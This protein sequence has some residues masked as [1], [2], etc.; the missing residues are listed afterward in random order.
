MSQISLLRNQ[1]ANI[2]P[3]P[4]TTSHFAY[5][6]ASNRALQR[7]QAHHSQ[8]RLGIEYCLA[9]GEKLSFHSVKRISCLHHTILEMCVGK[10]SK[11]MT[12]RSTH[13]RTDKGY[14]GVFL[15]CLFDEPAKKIHTLPMCHPWME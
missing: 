11:E 7:S 2:P 14:P 5:V 6:A 3:P 8:P 1:K 13:Q 4:S 12:V 9:P 10:S 15:F